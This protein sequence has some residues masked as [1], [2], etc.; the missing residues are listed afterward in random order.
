MAK[1]NV[2]EILEGIRRND[3]KILQYVYR[4]FY[5]YIKY[6]IISNSGNDDDARDIFQEALVVVYGSLLRIN[7]TSAVLLK[8]IST[9]LVDY[10]G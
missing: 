1:Y 10:S 6:F 8:L 5:S 7:L 9:P 3:I 4:T 2:E